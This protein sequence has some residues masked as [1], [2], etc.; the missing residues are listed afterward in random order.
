MTGVRFQLHPSSAT[1]FFIASTRSQRG[2]L[3]QL[4]PCSHRRT[5][6]RPAASKCSLTTSRARLRRAGCVSSTS[7]QLYCYILRYFCSTK[8]ARVLP[9]Q[10]VPRTGVVCVL[11]H[12]YER[13]Y[14]AF[15]SNELLQR[16]S[17]RWP[18]TNG[19]CGMTS[20]HCTAIT[21]QSTASTIHVSTSFD[22]PRTILVRTLGL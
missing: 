8:D 4:R 22:R 9:V 6:L 21:T 12:R 5:H 7:L 18:S 3:V 2:G 14:C 13:C 11:Y 19:T 17:Y 1:L 20:H 16:R 10:E 15:I